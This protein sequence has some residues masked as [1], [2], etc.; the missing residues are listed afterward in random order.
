M[1]RKHIHIFLTVCECGNNISKAAQ[2]LYMTQP[3]VSVSIQ[4]LERYYG[5][6]LFDRISRRLYLT[7]AGKEFQ[8]YALR[9]SALFDDM[10]KGLKNWDS[11]GVLRVGASMTIGSHFMPSYVETFSASH[12][13]V[14][15]QVL[16]APSRQLEEKLITNELDMALVEIPVHEN[17]LNAIPYMEDH[18]EIIAPARPPYLHQP[19][20]T[21]EDFQ[22][23]NFL[24]RE[25]GS[26]TRDIFDQVMQN[27]GLNIRPTWESVSATALLNAVIHG[28]G[29]T[30][31]PRHMITD[32]VRQGL[33]CQIQVPKLIFRQQF[34][35]VYHQ[36]KLLSNLIR[37]FIRVCETYKEEKDPT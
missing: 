37:D 1:T 26:G 9:I 13:H 4:E 5:I 34:Y 7:E 30:V 2:K 15:T 32:P 22:K 36:D 33:V 14:S 20:M 17:S 10:E 19:I 25:Q 35:I 27:A 3:A 28:A 21:P 31:L 6:T 8:S 16:I 29:I 23:Q 11:F 18:L 24:L 12:P